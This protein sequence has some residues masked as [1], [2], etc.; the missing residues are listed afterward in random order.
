[1][2]SLQTELAALSAKCLRAEAALGCTRTEASWAAAELQILKGR[3]DIA[4]TE[5][6]GVAAQMSEL[7]QRL[8]A[9]DRCLQQL[10]SMLSGLLQLGEQ[11]NT[12]APQPQSQSPLVN[13]PAELESRQLAAQ[14]AGLQQQVQEQ[15]DQLRHAE[16]DADLAWDFAN[17]LQR[18][19][20]KLPQQHQQAQQ[21]D[22]QQPV[23]AARPAPPVPAS[24]L[25]SS[26][27]KRLQAAKPARTQAAAVRP[28]PTTP[29]PSPPKQQ[30]HRQ[31][32]TAASPAPS[33]SLPSLRSGLSLASQTRPSRPRSSQTASQASEQATVHISNW[34]HGTA[35]Q[36]AG[37]PQPALQ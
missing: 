6:N 8:A 13:S 3:R 28:S 9:K 30:Q 12:V 18:Q 23:T 25:A 17:K 27:A 5:G 11:A 20:A 34:L 2:R 14:V 15:A 32:D 10:H 1:M 26:L 7:Q 35:Q 37:D 24:G 36:P 22:H 4:A 29:C 21:Q 33:A 19:H 31:K 16:H